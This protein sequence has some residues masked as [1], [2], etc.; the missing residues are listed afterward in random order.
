MANMVEGGKTPPMSASELQEIG[1]RI[2]IFAGGLVRAQARNA[3][4][5]FDSL[6]STGSN[7]AVRDRMVDFSGINEI[8]GTTDLLELG[9][10]YE[11]EDPEET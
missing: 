10:R 1:Y 7:A 5:Y 4:D 2:V 6:L 8:I 9:R 11:K 3:R